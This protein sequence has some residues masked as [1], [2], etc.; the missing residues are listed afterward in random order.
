MGKVKETSIDLINLISIYIWEIGKVDTL[1]NFISEQRP[2]L[3]GFYL[4]NK[5][6]LL[7]VAYENLK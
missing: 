4:E 1:D 6:Y 2:D 7:E 5:D 3:F